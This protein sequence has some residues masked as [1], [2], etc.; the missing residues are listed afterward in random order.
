MKPDLLNQTCCECGTKGE[1]VYCVTC[2]QKQVAALRQAAEIGLQYAQ[3]VLVSFDERFQRHKR[4]EPERK[5]I[6]SEIE[7]IEKALGEHH[8]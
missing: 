7:T 1:A 8:D 3:E 6:L 2:L 5:L 4:N